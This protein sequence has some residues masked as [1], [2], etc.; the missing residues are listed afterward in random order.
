VVQGLSLVQIA[1]EF[2]SSKNTIRNA[3]IKANIPLR[4]RQTSGKASN[5]HYGSR[6]VKGQRV[7]HLTEQRVIMTIVEMRD[8]GMSFPKIARFLS[9]VGIPTKKRGHKWHPEVVRQIYMK[10]T[11]IR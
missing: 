9:K 4:K 10:S 2:S 1:K 11:N 7:E 6:V 8:D 3:L 5:P